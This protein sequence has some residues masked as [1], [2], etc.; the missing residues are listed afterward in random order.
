M[1]GVSNMVHGTLDPF[2]PSGQR[3]YNMDLD[4]ENLAKVVSFCCLT[5]SFPWNPCF[6]EYI[7]QTYH[8]NFRGF[9]RNA[10]KYDIF[11][12]Q[13]KHCQFLCCIF[14]I[15]DSRVSIIVHM[16]HSVNRNCYLAITARWIDHNLN[17][18]K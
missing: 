17:L 16:G 18:Q 7:Q 1:V 10:I 8:S 9:S 3:K 6:I 12:I 2:N 4:R 14:S 5:Y 13:G 11:E 15:L